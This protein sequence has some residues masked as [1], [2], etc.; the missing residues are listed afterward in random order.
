MPRALETRRRPSKDYAIHSVEKAFDLLEAM[1]EGG[2]EL[3]ISELSQRLEMDKTNVFR[4]LSTFENRGYVERVDGSGGY[5]LGLPAYAMAQKLLSH[6]GLLRKAR[7]A[8]ARLARLSGEAVYFM[9]PRMGEVLFL[10]VADSSHQVKV[11][12]LV[13]RCF[14]LGTSAAGQVFRV[15]APNTDRPLANKAQ[16]VMEFPEENRTK[17]RQSGY[18][19]NENGIDEG[20]SLLSAPLFGAEGEVVAALAVLGP[21]YRLPRERIDGDLAPQLLETARGIS[22]SLGYHRDYMLRIAS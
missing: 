8:M 22:T 6:M 12:S 16:G 4:L 3:R 20:V 1:C 9:A 13:G 14:A 7:P 17:I 5:R 11:V 21:S 18:C 19:Y 10:D 15:F 2:G